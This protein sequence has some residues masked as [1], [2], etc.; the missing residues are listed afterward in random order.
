[1]PLQVH[2]LHLATDGYI[3]PHVDNIQASG[4]FI[5]GVSLG[6][7]RILHLE[8]VNANPSQDANHVPA[9]DLLLEPGSV[10]VQRDYTRYNMKHSILQEGTIGGVFVPHGQR[11]SIMIRDMPGKEEISLH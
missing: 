11:L 2:I 4:S 7:P 1:V 5:L 9:C 6:A 8:E 10:Y 3:L